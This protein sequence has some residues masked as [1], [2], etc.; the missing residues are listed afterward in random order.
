MERAFL[1]VITA[2]VLFN[3]ISTFFDEKMYYSVPMVGD[4]IY[5]YYVFI[6]YYIYKYRKHVMKGKMIPVRY[7]CSMHG[8]KLWADLRG[9]LAGWRTL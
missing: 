5:S 6:G 8:I 4:R 9:N 1:V 7:F 3:Y 2:A